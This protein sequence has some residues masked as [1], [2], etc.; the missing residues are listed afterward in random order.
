MDT[1][2]PLILLIDDEKYFLD[3]FSTKLTAS[4][5][6]VLCVE[7]GEAA[8]AKLKEITPDFV[9]L[10]V[11]MPILDGIETFYKIK[12]DFPQLAAKVA[13]LTAYGEDINKPSFDRKFAQEAGAAE[14]IR[15]S[16]DLDEIASKVKSL[17]GQASI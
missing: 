11:K 10:D 14:Y 5:F 4:G 13:F 7:S 16:D 1:K 15:K 6:D 3:I 2:K 8:L 12:S 17:V 9:L